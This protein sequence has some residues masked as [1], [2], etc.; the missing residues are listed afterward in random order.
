MRL[1]AVLVAASIAAAPVP[2]FAHETDALA[3]RLSDPAFQQ[4]ISGTVAV[5]SEILLD[6]P[7][8]PLAEAAAEMAGEDPAEV[9]PDLTLR[10]L[11][12]PDA[13]R[14][15]GEIAENLPR[16]MGSVAGVA[17]GFSAM[18][19]ALR[20]MARRVDAEIERAGP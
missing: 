19:P 7:I 17:E 4:E 12:G 13:E 20:E 1:S 8:A 5:M 14:V 3:E 11:A 15:P 6:L 16:I 10:Q 18:L 2:A 9:D